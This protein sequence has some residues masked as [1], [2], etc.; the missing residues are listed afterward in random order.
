[1]SGRAELAEE[2]VG[3][4]RHFA[5]LYSIESLFIVGGYCR[6]KV[7]GDDESVDDIDVASAFPRQA[8]SMC[9]LF[10]SEVLHTTPTFYQRTGTGMVEY[11]GMRI[12]FQNDSVNSYMQNPDVIQW[13]RSQRLPDVPVIN[14]VFGRDFTINSL[15]LGVS[16][17][18]FYDI[19]GRGVQDINRKTICSILPANILIRYNP[20]AIT[21]AI[22]FSIRYGFIIHPELRKAMKRNVESLFK[23]YTRERLVLEAKKILSS[24]PEKGIQA[25]EKYGLGRLLMDE[26]LSEYAEV[27]AKGE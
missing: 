26:S 13:M 12:E 3:L 23:A 20:L 22:R 14:N 6:A 21:R 4:I 7:M 18:K 11:N 24:N 9:G 8:M 10:A 5:K 1:M 17:D 19:T 2:V 15:L 25:L 27:V 16:D